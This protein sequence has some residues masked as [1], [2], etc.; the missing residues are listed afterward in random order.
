MRWYQHTLGDPT[1]QAYTFVA[2]P[3][4]LAV[5]VV[6]VLGVGRG[7]RGVRQRRL[8]KCRW[9]PA[10]TVPIRRPER[11]LAE[12]ERIGYPLL[13]KASAAAAVRV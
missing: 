1:M 7:A 12:S 6:V 5:V 8:P 10:T 3:L 13:I 2:R 9:F 4:T 11:L